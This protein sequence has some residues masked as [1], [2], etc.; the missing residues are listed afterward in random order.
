MSLRFKT[1]DQVLLL[2]K[3]ACR[4]ITLSAW[5]Q[6]TVIIPDRVTIVT[7]VLQSGPDKNCFELAAY[8]GARWTQE[9]KC[10]DRRGYSGI[11]HSQNAP[12]LQEYVPGVSPDWQEERQRILDRADVAEEVNDLLG[13]MNKWRDSIP[14]S[15]LAPSRAD[16]MNRLREHLLGAEACLKELKGDL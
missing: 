14:E 1:G 2:G 4:G 15:A 5:N 11:W 16:C 13:E 8:P 9:G 6:Y 12:Q 3:H 10:V 7:R